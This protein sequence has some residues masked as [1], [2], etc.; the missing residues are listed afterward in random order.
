MNE[1]KIISLRRIQY[2][3]DG[4]GKRIW[5]CDVCTKREKWGN[6]W[7]WYGSMRDEEQEKNSKPLII[8]CSNNCRASISNPNKFQNELAEL[9][10]QSN[11]LPIRF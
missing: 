1:P 8:T 5:I 10:K 7:R 2:M 3:F 9:E 6:D 4:E 11:K